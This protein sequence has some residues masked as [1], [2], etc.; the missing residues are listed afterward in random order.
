[1]VDAIGA[2]APAEVTAVFDPGGTSTG[3]VW[4]QFPES[5]NP[6]LHGLLPSIDMSPLDG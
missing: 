3:G 4:A 5:G 2:R 1:V 6:V